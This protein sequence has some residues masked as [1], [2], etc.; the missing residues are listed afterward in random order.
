MAGLLADF[1]PEVC[2]YSRW[3]PERR[4][5]CWLEAEPLNERQMLRRE[6]S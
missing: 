4:G 1:S 5:I 3:E 6:C 2:V